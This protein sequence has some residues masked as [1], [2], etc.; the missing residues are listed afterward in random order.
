MYNLA[1]SPKIR[2]ID[3]TNVP[4]LSSKESAEAIYK[5][6]KISGSIQVLLLGRTDIAKSLT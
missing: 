2:H 5:L 3:L 1:F 4:N 6:L